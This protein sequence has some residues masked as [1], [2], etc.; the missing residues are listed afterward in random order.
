V[1]FLIGELTKILQ[2]GKKKE[3]RKKKRG[4][5][6]RSNQ[7]FLEK[8]GPKLPHYERGKNYKVVIFREQVPNKLPNYKRKPIFFPIF[9]PDLIWLNPLVH[10]CRPTYFTKLK[11]RRR[12]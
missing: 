10:N 5:S 8:T 7:F 6:K 9:P 2:P 4:G 3:K 11:K 12:H 1:V